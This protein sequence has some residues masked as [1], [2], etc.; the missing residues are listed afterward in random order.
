MSIRR[1]S[2]WLAF[3]A[4]ALGALLVAGCGDDDSTSGTQTPG[5]LSGKLEIFSWWTTGGEAAGLQKLYDLYPNQC[6][7]SV[8]IVNSTVAGGGG[9]N[10]RQ[11]LTT[12]MLGNDPPGSFQV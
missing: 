5:A 6:G 4:V 11:V 3:V 8:Q 10:A 2:V 7:G 12:R 9:A 1:A